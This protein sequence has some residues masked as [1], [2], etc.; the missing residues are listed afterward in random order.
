MALRL[1]SQVARRR[2]RWRLVHEIASQE[3]PGDA[4]LH[5]SD[6]TIQSRGSLEARLEQREIFHTRSGTRVRA[7]LAESIRSEHRAFDNSS[8][9]MVRILFRRKQDGNVFGADA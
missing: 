1:L 8:G 3:H 6:R 4:L 9:R 7:E 5:S 2:D